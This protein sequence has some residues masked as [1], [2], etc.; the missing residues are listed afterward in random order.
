[1]RVASDQF[2]QALARVGLRD[3]HVPIVANISAR[4]ITSAE[5][6]RR[7]LADQITGSVRW[8]Q[9][10]KA[11]VEDGVQTIVEIGPGDALSGISRRISRDLQAFSVNSVEAIGQLPGRLQELELRRVRGAG[12]A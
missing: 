3:A 5:D 4:A 1:M 2:S 11:M 7:E 10:I 9:S 6:I 12:A 8:S